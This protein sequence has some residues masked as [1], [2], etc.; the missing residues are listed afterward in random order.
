MP[1]SSSRYPLLLLAH[2]LRNQVSNSA[3]TALCS[4]PGSSADAVVHLFS[5]NV[6]TLNSSSRRHRHASMFDNLSV[7]YLEIFTTG[8]EDSGE[9]E[10]CAGVCWLMNQRTV[11][12][13]ELTVEQ[14][15]V[16]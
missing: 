5:D 6:T 13:S 7:T 3:S 11:R 4:H 12:Q 9:S 8:M 15:K 1:G 10:L 16:E 2:Q 14:E